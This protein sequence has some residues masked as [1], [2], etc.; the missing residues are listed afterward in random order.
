[1]RHWKYLV[2]LLRH[3]WYAFVECRKLG[4]PVLGLLHDLSKFRPDEWLP[5]ANWFYGP[6]YSDQEV[7]Q[8]MRVGVWL[9][10]TSELGNQFD[11]AWLHHQRRNKHHY[12]YWLLKEDS[13]AL[14]PLKMP[15][16]YVL[17]MIADWRA[18]S[19]AITGT[20]NTPAWYDE[21]ADLIVLHPRTRYLVE[22][23]LKRPRTGWEK[24]Q[25]VRDLKVERSK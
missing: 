14:K 10:Y 3:K 21:H 19:R 11:Y 7:H 4:V 20:D 5:Y 23:L 25:S 24:W 18:A 13:G 17:E 16:R 2:Y 1:M 12:Q 22:C 15:K 6:R 9:P 8:A